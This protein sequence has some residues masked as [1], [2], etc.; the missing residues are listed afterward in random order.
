M[1]S[2]VKYTTLYSSIP[3]AGRSVRP[4]VCLLVPLFLRWLPEVLGE[5]CALGGLLLLGRL[6]DVASPG[7]NL[8]LTVHQDL[9]LLQVLDGRPTL[10]WSKY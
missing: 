8:L 5:D 7:G 10:P 2:A 1:Y 9:H 4:G 6:E 3:E